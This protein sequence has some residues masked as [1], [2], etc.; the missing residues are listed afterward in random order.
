MPVLAE[1]PDACPDARARW[2]SPSGR[3]RVSGRVTDYGTRKCL[4]GAVSRCWNGPQ[5]KS[6]T[7]PCWLPPPEKGQDFSLVVPPCRSPEQRDLATSRAYWPERQH[8]SGQA[9]RFG[10]PRPGHDR[11]DGPEAGARLLGLRRG[12]T[13]KLPRTLAI[14]LTFNVSAPVTIAA[15][16]DPDPPE[17]P[18][19][20][21]PVPELC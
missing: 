8:A 15:Q 20:S 19:R 6:R 18:D 21:S 12:T 13:P 9:P 2:L 14:A 16:S 7:S 3:R 17:M 5:R 11:N 10:G 1:P 4:A